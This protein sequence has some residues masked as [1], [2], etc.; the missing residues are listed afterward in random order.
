LTI[1]PLSMIACTALNC[2]KVMLRMQHTK[3][4]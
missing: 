1:L 2:L 3:V 4:F